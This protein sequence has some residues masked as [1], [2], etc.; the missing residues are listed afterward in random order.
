MPSYIKLFKEP[1]K[2]LNDLIMA[3]TY[4]KTLSL[5][6]NSLFRF[7]NVATG[8]VVFSFCAFCANNQYAL[9][10]YLNFS[11]TKIL[12]FITESQ[13]FSLVRINY[14]KLEKGLT[15]SFSHQ[16]SGLNFSFF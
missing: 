16:S 14:H 11:Q 7:Q 3:Q 15:L 4:A 9:Y 1:I 8:D 2:S 10:V 5:L 6:F 13:V 12:K